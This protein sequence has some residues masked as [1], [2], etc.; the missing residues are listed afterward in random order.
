MATISGPTRLKLRAITAAVAAAV[1]LALAAHPAPASADVVSATTDGVDATLNL[2]SA[3]DV[4][5]V[6]V[7]NGLLV[8]DPVGAGLKSSADWDTATP[9]DQT[10]AANGGNLITING[11]AGNDTL[12]VNAPGDAIGAAVLN[13]D[14]GDDVL[15]GSG[16]GDSLN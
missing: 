3:D 14:G 11:G 9:G 1:T 6:S 13:G 7:Q 8:H 10:V 15:T 2:D 4:V 5:T 12:T 16:G